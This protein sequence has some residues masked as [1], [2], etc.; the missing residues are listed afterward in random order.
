MSEVKIILWIMF[1]A[2]LLLLYIIEVHS[3]YE[4]TKGVSK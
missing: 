3:I 1:I 2:P 4:S